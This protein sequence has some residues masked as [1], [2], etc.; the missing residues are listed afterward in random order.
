MELLVT[1]GGK[2]KGQQ[3]F[4]KI[5]DFTKELDYA[6]ARDLM[7]LIADHLGFALTILPEYL[8]PKTQK[9]QP[10]CCPVCN[11]AGLVSAGLYGDSDN[12]PGTA[13]VCR[14]CNG[15]GVIWR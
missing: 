15:Q 11:G 8:K 1:E 5:G 9:Q 2:E 13:V 10:H 6:D 4:I 7:Y 14:T 3:V 12:Y